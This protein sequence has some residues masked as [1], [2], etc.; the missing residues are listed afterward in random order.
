MLDSY[1]IIVP[2]LDKRTAIL[3]TLESVQASMAF[4]EAN[5]P[6]ACEIT[7]EIV[8]VD[9]GSTDGTLELVQDFARTHPRLKL[10]RHQR[11]LGIGPARNTG[12][13]A[14]HGQVLFF[15]DGDDRF[16]PEHVFLG[17]SVLDYSDGA[18]GSRTIRL[19]IGDRGH[20][21]FSADQPVAALR[22]GVRLEENLLPFWRAAINNTIVQNL[23]VRR[24]CHEWGEGF[25]E[26][27]VYKRIGGCEDVA[28]NSWLNIFFRVGQLSLETVEYLRYPGNSLDRQLK[29]FQHPPGSAHDAATPEQQA[30]LDIRLRR[31]HERVVYLLDKWKALGPPPLPPRLLNWDNLADELLVRGRIADACRV[32]DTCRREGRALSERL[33]E[34]IAAACRAD[35]AMGSERP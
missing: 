20:V 26:E 27:A 2:V 31:E 30:L 33:A 11:S 15:C 17:F 23:C 34:R 6:R 28:Y 3:P 8:V 13:R 18:R 29:R 22:T 16:L 1:S 32:A 19:R 12:V 9:E 24:E 10:V 5:H 14:S 25:P 21:T 7:A 35:Q 4:F